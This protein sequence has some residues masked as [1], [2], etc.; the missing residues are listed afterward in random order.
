MLLVIEFCLAAIAVAAA[1]AFPNIGSRWFGMV[2]R[3]FGRF[4]QRR[5]R[6]VLAVGLL[7]LA[8]RAAL[9]PILPVPKPSIADEFGYLL[10]GDTFAHGRLTN[11][12]HP[13]WIHFET[14]TI[15]QKP[16]YTSVFY[17]AQGLFLALGQVI[18]GYPFVGVW[19]SV[20]V[21][22][23]AICWML[24]GW[25]PPNWALL[26]GCLAV[27]RLGTFSY[28]ANSYF[29]GAVAA[30]GGA[31]V[32]G[33]L[34]R[35]KR[36]LRVSNALLMGIGLAILANSR[37]YESVFLGLP[38]GVALLAWMLGK[39]GPS[40]GTSMRRILLPIGLVLAL[41]IGGMMYYF[42][43]TTGSPFNSPYLIN[44]ATYFPV[45]AFPWQ[46]PTKVLNYHH[47]DMQYFYEGSKYGGWPVPSYKT[48]RANPGRVAILKLIRFW[49][50]YLG[51]ILT[52]PFLAW[53]TIKPCRAI[54][55]S[56]SRKTRFLLLC[57][58]VFTFGLLLPI[59]FNP[60][61]AAPITCCLYAL[62][63]QAMRNM[64]L[65]GWRG[66]RQGIFLTRAIPTIC[67]VMLLLRAAVPL[68]HIS[69]E[70]T[71]DYSWFSPQFESVG[72]AE[73][74]SRLRDY[75]GNQL[76]I[77]RYK[78]DHSDVSN[79]LVYNEA[80]IDRSRIVWARDMGAAENEE[81]VRYFKGRRIWLAE[82]DETPLRLSPYSDPI[83]SAGSAAEDKE[84]FGNE[85]H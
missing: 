2:E 24:Q 48:A 57:C 17:P 80:D 74:L 10:S 73:V 18:S 67:L 14:Y 35:I 77:V 43:R 61:Y 42:W 82:P 21:M 12:T 78:P 79:E 30:I 69:L 49:L 38:V 36:R 41:T 22:C 51:P 85:K 68:L 66:E 27:I 3:R 59:F 72:R 40:F 84:S 26:G 45:P 20:G 39:A 34:P 58:G 16:T 55:Q 60:H 46:S 8:T 52:L 33:A 28:W 70:A 19:L 81:L 71:W 7:A 62:L 37:P 25:L 5:G 11:P 63:L 31:L 1:Y 56:I 15:I 76:V 13:M 44:M 23:A 83:L 32:L 50:F 64:R 47:P 65:W 29:G 9:L 4:A 75:P 6:A 53:V 54:Y